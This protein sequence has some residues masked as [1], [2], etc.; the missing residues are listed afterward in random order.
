VAAI[1]AFLA[2][3]VA[4]YAAFPRA[5]PRLAGWS[6][7]LL[8]PG[9]AL[10]RPAPSIDLS[11]QFGQ[12]VSL[13]SMRGKVVVLAFIDSEC[14]TMCPLTSQAMLDA[15][16][17]LG[18]AR[19]NVQLV[20]VDANPRAT[21]LQDVMAYSQVHGM[22]HAWDFLTGSLSALRRVWHDYSIDAT[23]SRRSVD[24]TPAIFLINPE[25]RLVR[26]YI[27]QQSYA[28]IGQL[29]Q[30]IAGRTASL[31]RPHPKVD[32]KLSYK[33]IPGI[34]PTST[35][36]LPQ[37]GGGNLWD[38]QII[39]LGGGLDGLNAYTATAARAGLPKLTA[40]DAGAVEP[41]GAL[42]RF[43]HGL[44]KPLSYS[45]AVDT[46]GRLAD[47]YEVESEPWMM[48]VGANGSID[49]YYSVASLGWPTTAKLVADVREALKVA[50]QRARGTSAATTQP[51]APPTLEKLRRQAS[52]ILGS[53][54]ALD[55]RIKALR[56]YPIVINVWASWCVPCRSEFG[57]FRTASARYGS[58]VAFVGADADDSAGDAKSF[59]QQHPVNYPSYS[60]QTTQL[61]PL[62]SIEGLP[63]TIYINRA[64]R[65]AYVHTGQYSNQKSLDGDIAAYAGVGRS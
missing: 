9:T 56:G 33:L 29:G 52:Q 43:L 41:Q 46:T 28:A 40:I 42:T 18:P 63:T 2:I 25:G 26:E 60:V 31:L 3:A 58:S 36:T 34:Y 53:Y 39:D 12:P 6:N 65:V 64:G 32:S 62:A 30:L 51:T 47:G 7:P 1:G 37:A 21:A 4:G 19:R 48:L 55:A 22:L 20:G 57:L 17:M 16:A 23:I 35:A 15:K 44:T 14:T 54:P 50:A 8:D 49:W 59:L 45:V 10:A 38:R 61:T 13:A 11:N 27:V 5:A 24:H